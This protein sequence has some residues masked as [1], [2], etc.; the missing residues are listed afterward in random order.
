VSA[1][2]LGFGSYSSLRA[3]PTDTTGNIAVTCS[4]VPG[5][6]VAYTIALASGGSGTFAARSMRNGV[7]TLFYNIYGTASRAIVWGDGNAATMVV[8]DAFSLPGT[9]IT[10]NYP[11][12]GRTGGR[13][14]VPV[15]VYTDSI[16]VTLTF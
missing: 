6:P 9:Q 5:E 4:G 1:V 15:G 3:A 16:V 12:Y 7:H 8:A 13:Q 11:V 10:R 14:N 2:S